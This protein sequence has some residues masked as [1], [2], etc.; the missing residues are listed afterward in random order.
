VDLLSVTGLTC[1][2]KLARTG[3]VDENLELLVLLII[4]LFIVDED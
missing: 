4:L 1:P 2:D 3:A